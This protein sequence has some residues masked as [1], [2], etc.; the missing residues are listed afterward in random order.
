MVTFMVRLVMMDVVVV[1]V[2]VRTVVTVA[3]EAVVVED[4]VGKP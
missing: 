1:C 4:G 2:V 3:L